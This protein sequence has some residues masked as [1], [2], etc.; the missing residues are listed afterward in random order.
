MVK[1]Q[2]L[3]LLPCGGEGLVSQRFLRRRRRGVDLGPTVRRH[4]CTHSS[5][6]SQ[7]RCGQQSGLPG[8]AFGHRYPGH[9]FEGP[10]H[11]AVRAGGPTLPQTL[12]QQW[13]GS[14]RAAAVGL[15]VPGAH[16]VTAINTRGRGH[17]GRLRTGVPNPGG[18]PGCAALPCGR[19]A[20]G[21]PRGSLKSE[22]VS[23]RARNALQGPRGSSD[24]QK[25]PGSGRA[26]TGPPS[27]GPSSLGP[28]RLGRASVGRPACGRPVLGWPV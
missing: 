7:C 19:A 27:L 11:Q 20:P 4:W 25:G 8:V 1:G 13:E 10:H 12:L 16:L 9:L 6:P 26:K 2:L 21:L 23:R 15:S 22:M 28:P 5:P 24:H 14:A 17:F 3:I 18:R